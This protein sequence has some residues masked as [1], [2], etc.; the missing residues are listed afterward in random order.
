MINKCDIIRDLIPLYAENMVSEGTKEFVDKHCTECSQCREI[1][2]TALTTLGTKDHAEE[3][4]EKI[5]NTMSKRERRI[6]VIRRTIISLGA[7]FLVLFSIFFCSFLIKGNT[8]FTKFDL[9]AANDYPYSSQTQDHTRPGKD[10]VEAAAEAVKKYFRNN[11]NACVLLRLA[12]D[13]D[14][15]YDAEYESQYPESIVFVSDYY[16]LTEPVAGD[17]SR[18]RN[19]WRWTVHYDEK[20]SEWKVVNFG[21]G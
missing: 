12:Y 21:Y 1:L 10:E 16:M 3:R 4:K 14:Y 6:K 13:E 11:F 5:W 19:S 20:N 9:G 17:S 15:T 2:N 18:M 8:W 7:T